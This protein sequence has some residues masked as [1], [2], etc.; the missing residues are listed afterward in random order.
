MID[1]SGKHTKPAQA[2]L[3]HEATLRFRLC[4]PWSF[5]KELADHRAARSSARCSGQVRSMRIEIEKE[6][7]RDDGVAQ[8]QR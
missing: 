8:E 4:M 7:H 1:T 3:K 6:D 5:S 2:L